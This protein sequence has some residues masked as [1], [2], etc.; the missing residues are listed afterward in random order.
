MATHRAP[1][2]RNTVDMITALTEHSGKDV[3][4]PVLATVAFGPEG[5]YATDSYTLGIGPSLEWD[6]PLGEDHTDYVLVDAKE[7]KKALKTVGPNKSAMFDAGITVDT[8]ARTV[9]VKESE[10]TSPRGTRER[11]RTEVPGAA[12]T[13]RTTEGAFPNVTQLIPDTL[14]EDA[15]PLPAVCSKKL[16]RFAKLAEAVSNIEDAHGTL[17]AVHLVADSLE[18]GKATPVIRVDSWTGTVI[19]LIMPVRTERSV[20]DVQAAHLAETERTGEVAA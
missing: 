8:E 16:G 2:D 11:E 6:H 12:V 18:S 15:G 13:M 9:T 3:R 19:G 20:R 1:L 5:T 7:L 10:Y 4:R 17:T 14:Y